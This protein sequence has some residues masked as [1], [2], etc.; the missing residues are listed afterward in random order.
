MTSIGT[1]RNPTGEVPRH[2][3]LSDVEGEIVL[4]PEYAPGL[5]GLEPGDRIVVLFLF[6]E[7]PEFT[8][9]ALVQHPKHHKGPRGV[10]SICSPLRPNPIGLSVVEILGID[11]NILS[12]R[13]IDMRDGTPVIDVKPART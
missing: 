1:I 8:D 2:H 9:D 11:G 13:G 7:S 10:F 12:V 6:H 3:T 5:K 4:K